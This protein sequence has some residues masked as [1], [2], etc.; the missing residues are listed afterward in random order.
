MASQYSRSLKFTNDLT[1]DDSD[2]ANFEVNSD[3]DGED[4]PYYL[5]AGFSLDIDD[6]VE[7]AN[8]ADDIIKMIEGDW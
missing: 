5:E 3:S 2:E 4:L 6:E 1:Y 7:E 8:R